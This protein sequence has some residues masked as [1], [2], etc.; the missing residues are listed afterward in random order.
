MMEPM[1]PM[2]P[3]RASTRLSIAWAGRPPVED[4]DTLVLTIEGLSVDLRVFSCGSQR[5]EI[6]W[7][8]VGAISHGEG[9]S[10]ATPRLI[11]TQLLDSRPPPP[12]AAS[13]G[14]F[15]ILNRTDVLESGVM[16]NPETEKDEA[17]DEVWRRLPVLPGSEYVVL[18]RVDGV[19]GNPGGGEEKAHSMPRAFVARLGPW[20]L[21]LG[22][23]ET[24]EF[25]AY[26]DEREE[27]WV[28]K[29]SFGSGLPGLTDAE[30]GLRVGE[31]VHLD[32]GEWVVCA[33]GHK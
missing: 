5:G 15:S 19:Y 25:V 13:A 10:K 14:A 29:Y 26:R 27:G 6:D 31:K 9:H 2:G 7:A 4:T 33:S 3:V 23:S 30:L 17:Y 11:W 20:T 21:G 24:G 8:S 16:Y 22:R 28:R 12:T 18:E 1:D 32:V